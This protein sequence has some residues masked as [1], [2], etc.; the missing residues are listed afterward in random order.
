MGSTDT[1]EAPLTS[2]QVKEEADLVD[3]SCLSYKASYHERNDRKALTSQILQQGLDDWRADE[4]M[5]GSGS[6][7]FT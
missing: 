2:L 1:P 7:S 6:R 3:K 4:W 5:G